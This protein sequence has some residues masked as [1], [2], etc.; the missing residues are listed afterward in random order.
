[1]TS[2]R[3]IAANRLNGRKSRGP[4]TAA[5]KRIASR[6]ALRH[7][8]AAITHRQP[9]SSDEIER[10]AKALCGGDDDPSLLEQARVI[11][12]NELVRR[13][14]SAQQLAVVERVR[15]RSA[16]ALAKGD[17]GVALGEAR[18]LKTRLA[19]DG[20]AMFCDRLLEKYKDELPPPI[21]FKKIN[22]FL[23]E[24]DLLIPLHL[25]IFLEDKEEQLA[26]R[27]L[28]HSEARVDQIE[29]RTDQ[30]DEAAA[31]Q[32]AALDLIRLDRYERRAWSRQMRAFRAFMDRKFLKLK[33]S[34][35]TH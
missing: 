29:E 11:A 17:N 25:R 24:I 2:E 31:M 33:L 28:D 27:A 19:Y 15:D 20:L 6:N 4:R 30:R 34:R 1:M 23:P 7:G 8:L 26:S 21:R 32:E 13:A 9:V 3:K 22:E 5:G 18:F 16:I 10:F 12:G 14:I 35:T